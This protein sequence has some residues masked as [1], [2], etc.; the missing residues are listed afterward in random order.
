M[1]ENFIEISKEDMLAYRG[2]LEKESFDYTYVDSAT[3]MQAT[4][5][6]DTVCVTIVW[7]EEKTI[8]IVTGVLL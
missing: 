4:L 1:V 8:L 3:T 7:T 6:L 5:V 2:A